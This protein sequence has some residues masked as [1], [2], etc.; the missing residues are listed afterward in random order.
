[1][2][3]SL[4]ILVPTINRY[5]YLKELIY[6]INSFNSLE[7]ELVIQD[8]STDNSEFLSYLNKN[9]YPWINY[10]YSSGYLTS[11][12]NFDKAVMNSKGEYLCFIGD[13]DGVVRN[14]TTYVYWM[15]KNNIDALRGGR[16][17]YY[18]PETGIN[19]G[20][21]YNDTISKKVQILKP[22]TELNYMLSNGCQG[23]S[24]I[25]LLYTGIVKKSILE[26]IYKIGGT[27]F[28]GA[29]GD[30]A[31][32][33]ALC[34]LVKKYAYIENPIVISGTS[35]NTGG[36]VH[37]TKKRR[38]ELTDVSFIS[39]TT[40]TDWEK[41][42]PPIWSGLLVWPESA[43]KALRYMS[44]EIYIDKVNLNLSLAAFAVKNKSYFNLAY[45]FAKS[46]SKFIFYFLFI[47]VKYVFTGVLDKVI[48]FKTQNKKCIGG[49]IHY[50]VKNIFDAENILYQKIGDI[51]D[52]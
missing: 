2:S 37:K 41:T 45:R 21:L 46:K 38:L 19:G 50:N 29:S 22:I 32:G 14:V 13:D 1:M 25:P 47:I 16:S 33:V 20:F 18:W 27:Y 9:K 40:V 51:K 43:I 26:E 24:K 35:R 23:L 31:N 44:K 42:I 3:Y 12:E 48:R 17:D 5:P 6:L 39:K 4:S 8:N 49:D 34:F 30:I 28:P 7:I 15:K 10:S 11:V 52:L 36:G